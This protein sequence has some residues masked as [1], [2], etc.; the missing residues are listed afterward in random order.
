[1]FNLF[2]TLLFIKRTEILSYIGAYEA[3]SLGTMVVFS[4]CSFS[5]ILVFHKC[6][7]NAYGLLCQ[8]IEKLQKLVFD[9]DKYDW[10]LFPS[11]YNT[12]PHIFFPDVL[13]GRSSDS[14]EVY[15]AQIAVV[16]CLQF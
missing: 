12:V 14:L 1:M 6:A 9:E 10:S 13:I 11:S 8:I 7:R 3:E 16:K 4:T 5:F 15:L 2:D